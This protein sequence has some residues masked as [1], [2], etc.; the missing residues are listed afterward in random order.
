MSPK[1][2]YK[3]V[4]GCFGVL[5]QFYCRMCLRRADLQLVKNRKVTLSELDESKVP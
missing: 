3:T 1:Q 2:T 5:F 4:S